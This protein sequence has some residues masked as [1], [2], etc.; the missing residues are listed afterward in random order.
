MLMQC[1]SGQLI[2]PR[3]FDNTVFLK[4][5]SVFERIVEKQSGKK[6]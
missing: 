3:T 4:Y 1:K 6:N 2:P 5:V